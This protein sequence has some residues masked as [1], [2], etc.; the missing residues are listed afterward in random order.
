MGYISG[1]YD[2]HIFDY[3]SSSILASLEKIKDDQN[4]NFT[5]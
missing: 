3:M 2:D 4:V 1:F 5:K